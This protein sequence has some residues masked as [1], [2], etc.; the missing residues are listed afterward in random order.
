MSQLA[1]ALPD[2][3]LTKDEQ[4]LLKHMSTWWGGMTYSTIKYQL[5][6]SDQ[7]AG[8]VVTSLKTRGLIWRCSWVGE[9]FIEKDYPQAV[10]GS[11]SEM[12]TSM[13]RRDYEVAGSV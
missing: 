13:I 7:K 10:H 5:G 9:F 1:L 8:P 3:P 11:R 12:F 2:M 4:L 6:W